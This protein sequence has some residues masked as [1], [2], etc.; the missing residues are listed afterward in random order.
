MT[1]AESFEKLEKALAKIYLI[2]TDGNKVIRTTEHFMYMETRGKW[3]A[4]KS[5]ETRNYLYLDIFTGRIHI[6]YEDKP[7]FRGQF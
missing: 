1:T 5:R 7:F 4:F 2:D 6:P 3:V